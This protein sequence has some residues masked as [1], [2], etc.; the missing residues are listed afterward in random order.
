M[1]I[2]FT[3]VATTG[4]G[5][6]KKCGKP[7]N[8]WTDTRVFGQRRGRRSSAWEEFDESWQYVFSDELVHLPESIYGLQKSGGV[9]HGVTP[10]EIYL[11]GRGQLELKFMLSGERDAEYVAIARSLLLHVGLHR[12]REIDLQLTSVCRNSPVLVEVTHSV[13]PPQRMRFI[14]CPSVV[15]LKRFDFRDGKSRNAGRLVGKP[16]SSLAIVFADDGELGA[17]GTAKPSGGAGETP[18]ELIKVGTHTVKGVSSCETDGIGNIGEPD[19][20]DMLLMFKVIITRAGMG[21]SFPSV[22]ERLQKR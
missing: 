14:G 7:L 16:F 13:Q 10:A 18:D 19:L 20:K 17:F 4:C 1:G 6:P 8:N 11:E 15:R 12:T 22:N 3:P 9:S 21:C 5:F 2:H